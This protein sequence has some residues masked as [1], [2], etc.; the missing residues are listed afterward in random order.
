[1][2]IIKRPNGNY[3]VKYRGSDG[4]WISETF[5]RRRDA[6]N[7]DSKLKQEKRGGGVV[8]NQDREI[9]LDEFFPIWFET[10]KLQS[11]EGW[12]KQRK[13]QYEEYVKPVLG[14][15]RIQSIQPPD[16]AAVLSRMLKT[17]LSAQSMLHVYALLHKLFRDAQE[18]FR[19][20]PYNPVLRTYKPSVPRKEAPHLNLDQMRKL[21]M[22]VRGKPYGHA[23]WMHFYLGLRVSELQ[24]LRWQDVDLDSGVVFIRRTYVRKERTFRDY[25]KG[26]KQH[27][28]PIPPEALSIL[29]ELQDE[30]GTSEFVV[31]SEGYEMLSYEWYQ[32]SLVRYCKELGLPRIGTHGLRHSTSA[33]YLSSGANRDEIRE[34]MAHSSEK[35]TERY[36]HHHESRLGSLA[37]VIRLFPGSSQ[38]ECSQNVPKSDFDDEAAATSECEEN[39]TER[40]N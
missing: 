39:I 30:R 36:L 31:R 32:R 40:V 25:P 34:L 3:Q 2:A 1:M 29:M 33:L 18:S 23:I 9:T 19:L 4:R 26:K 28:K 20:V 11:S 7:F 14:Q 24:A 27:W 8:R 17:G 37:K 12:Y 13:Y 35:V 22:H 16:I 21:L 15:R 5:L 6:E 10:A 38:S